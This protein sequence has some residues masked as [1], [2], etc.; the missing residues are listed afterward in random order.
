MGTV[1]KVVGK[2]GQIS[3]G[4]EYAGRKI[5][6]EEKEPGYW[7]IRTGEFVPDNEL[8]IHEEPARSRIDQGLVWVRENRPSET[9]LEKLSEAIRK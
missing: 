3:L 8:W 2:S 9:D 4:K 5:L 1:I 7:I 6:L